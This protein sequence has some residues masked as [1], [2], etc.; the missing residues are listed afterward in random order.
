VLSVPAGTQRGFYNPASL[1]APRFGFAWSPFAGDRTTI[2]GGFG[3]YYN[4]PE[5][6]LISSMMN[7]PPYLQTVQLTNGFLQNLGGATA[8]APAPI[9][10]IYAVDP[11][12]HVAYTMNFSLSVQRQLPKGV[13]AE[14]AYVGNEGRHL[15]RQPDINTPTFANYQIISSYPSAS[16]PSVNAYRPYAGFSSI[17]MRVSDSNSNYNAL[18]LY[19]TK[20]KGDLMVS[21]SYTWS[22]ALSDSSTNTDNPEDPFARQF[23]YGPT[24]YD[25]RQIFVTNFN[26]NVPLFRR[27]RGVV[28]S[29][30]GGWALSGT[31]RAQTGP[32]LS[33]TED[34]ITGVMRADY[35]GGPT[36]LPSDQR[37]PNHW[38]NTAAFVVS[39]ETRRGNSGMGIITGPGMYLWDTSLRKN[40]RLT[41]RFRLRF[42]ADSTNLMNHSNFLSLQTKITNNQYGQVRAAAP[43]RNLQF[44]LRLQF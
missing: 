28:G 4:R 18:Q 8:A 37:T 42:Q 9:A 39:P 17:Y 40:F 25:R 5:L 13:F 21:A 12:L 7:T 1:F 22:K 32:E 24:T 15:Q 34:G 38:F 35:I 11:M 43:P 2:R 29:A 16:R 20:R 36:T 30:L 31:V 6:S 41:E 10:N 19:M 14:I 27:R 33:V 26:Y 3:M 23:N 44:G